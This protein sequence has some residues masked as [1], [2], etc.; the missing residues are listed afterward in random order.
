MFRKIILMIS[1]FFAV[2]YTHAA[3][4][5]QDY[6]VS[7]EDGTEINI[8]F[9]ESIL[10]SDGNYMILP[11][12]GDVTVS[13]PWTQLTVSS[14][15]VTVIGNFA[16]VVELSGSLA[17][18]GTEQTAIFTDTYLQDD[19]WVRVRTIHKTSYRIA[20]V[21]V[22]A[23]GWLFGSALIGLFGIKRKK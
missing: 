14:L 6:S 5:L 2:N 12:I 9:D 1:I 7:Y 3:V 23:A 8:V 16:S 15:A 20:A 17:V 21:P 10:Y 11:D 22:P 4:Y 19:F 13:S 18:Q